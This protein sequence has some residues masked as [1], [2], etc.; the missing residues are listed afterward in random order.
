M[1]TKLSLDYQKSIDAMVSER[2]N[3]QE[4]YAVVKEAYN[5][6]PKDIE[7]IWRWA[8][9]HYQL[10]ESVEHDKKYD[11]FKAGLVAATDALTLDA[12]HWGGHKWTASMTFSQLFF[13]LSSFITSNSHS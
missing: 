11:I 3:P 13:P 4:I 9:A 8:R 7:I 6:Y 2:K 5:L 1:S 12:T 10:G